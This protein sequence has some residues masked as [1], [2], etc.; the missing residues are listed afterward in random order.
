MIRWLAINKRI[1]RWMHDKNA[2]ENSYQLYLSKGIIKHVPKTES[3]VNAHME[4]SD[5]NIEFSHFLISSQKYPDWAIVGFYYALYHASLALLANVGFSSKDHTA[6][7]CFLM[8]H[9]AV[10][11]EEDLK[12]YDNLVL[13]KDEVES[14]TTLKDE[15]QK[16]SYSTEDTFDLDNV[17]ILREKSIRFINKVK[18]T[19]EEE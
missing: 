11:S 12:L 14:Y 17:N 7:L 1:K 5:H 9:Y 10:F 16:A 19:L 2:L 8:R 6:T 4:K 3:L 18:S 15:R 13:T